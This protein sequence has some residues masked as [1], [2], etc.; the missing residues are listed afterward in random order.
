MGGG[1]NGALMIKD[2]FKNIV[3]AIARRLEDLGLIVTYATDLRVMLFEAIKNNDI[4][5]AE[6]LI[7]EGADV[8]AAATEGPYK[9]Q[10]PLWIAVEKGD[11]KLAEMLIKKGAEVNAVA[12]VDPYA[13]QT[14]LWKAINS[15]N[16]ELAKLLI[17]AGA[18]VD[19]A[20]T[21]GYFKGETPLWRAI[22]YNYIE[23]AKL[24]INAGANVNVPPTANN[25]VDKFPLW[26]AI[27]KDNTTLTNLL[28]KKGAD[29]NAK[30]SNSITMLM[31]A[32]TTDKKELINS[33]VK[34]KAKWMLL[35]NS[36][37]ENNIN[38]E[39]IKNLD[40]VF[41]SDVDRIKSEIQ[42]IIDNKSVNGYKIFSSLLLVAAQSKNINF[43]PMMEKMLS[44]NKNGLQQNIVTLFFDNPT[45]F[46][47]LVQ[48]AD[49]TYSLL[50]NFLETIVNHVLNQAEKNGSLQELIA[51][52]IKQC[53]DDRHLMSKLILLLNKNI[54]LKLDLI[55][56]ELFINPDEGNVF[57]YFV[58]FN[59]Y[60]EAIPSS[61]LLEDVAKIILDPPSSR[62]LRIIL[63]EISNKD[64]DFTKN[65]E[66]LLL[67]KIASSEEGKKLCELMTARAI[68]NWTSFEF[69]PPKNISVAIM[70]AAVALFKLEDKITSKANTEIDF[71]PLLIQTES[72]NPPP[73]EV[74]NF[75]VTNYEDYKYITYPRSDEHK[76]LLLE[77]MLTKADY[78]YKQ[79]DTSN[80]IV[81][82]LEQYMISL[83][84]EIPF[85]KINSVELLKNV[86]NNKA[87]EFIKNIILFKQGF[88]IDP[89]LKYYNNGGEQQQQHAYLFSYNT[90]LAAKN[91][92]LNIA[93]NNPEHNNKIYN[94]KI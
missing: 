61:L 44:D 12:T 63:A 35:P 54:N 42:I 81:P 34:Y 15:G 2:F 89:S 53:G 45:L 19:T 43:L 57:N 65:P 51:S 29:V 14:P 28:I 86:Y 68:V 24:L 52:L 31:K 50:Y 38:S 69:E 36:F 16:E 56:K 26:L 39:F 71:N 32:M 20:P 55:L 83:L 27:Q 92:D 84:V 49:T 93:P 10:K 73:S 72:V 75:Y 64:E 85:S 30:D 82:K 9:G 77:Y 67:K 41:N 74:F 21:K 25:Y 62:Y 7:S 88:V 76:L 58:F 87:Q 59:Q 37:I 66:W 18:N 17:I 79:T 13:G 48:C 90:V 5:K 33:L 47:D 6:S 80:V 46:T 23:L 94:N 40:I 22:R 3:T 8:N 60:L 1:L 4:E 78:L 70:Q 11:T 91:K